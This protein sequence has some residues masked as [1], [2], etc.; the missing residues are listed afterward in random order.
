MLPDVFIHWGVERAPRGKWRVWGGA[1]RAADCERILVLP[2]SAPLPAGVEHDTVVRTPHLNDDS[3]WF[4]RLVPPAVS[5][6][7]DRRQMRAARRRLARL[8]AAMA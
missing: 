2:E 1:F 5:R 3:D 6:T 7:C 4:V 8:T